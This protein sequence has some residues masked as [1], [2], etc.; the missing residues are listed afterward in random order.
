MP[1][2]HTF[3]TRK[4]T[5]MEN[6]NI[7]LGMVPTFGSGGYFVVMSFC[8]IILVP[9]QSIPKICS[10]SSLQKAGKE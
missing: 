4:H 2:R 9:V 5:Q 3:Q 8:Y 1:Y 6:E 10:I 7:S